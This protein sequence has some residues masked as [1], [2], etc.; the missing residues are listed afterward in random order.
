MITPQNIAI[1]LKE[2][3]DRIAQLIAS[4]TKNNN[5]TKMQQQTK[6]PNIAIKNQSNLINRNNINQ[7]NNITNN[8]NKKRKLD[9]LTVC[10]CSYMCACVRLC[11][12]LLCVCFFFEISFQTLC[13]KKIQQ[14]KNLY[15]N[16]ATRKEKQR[17]EKMI[18]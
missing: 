5:T 16:Q 11:F 9:D 14:K 15:R 4:Q 10:L 7:N 2:F 1:I 17:K 18:I 8:N 12:V 6:N 13:T 3:K